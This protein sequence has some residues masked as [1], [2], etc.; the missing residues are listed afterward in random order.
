[1]SKMEPLMQQN[2]PD[3]VEFVPLAEVIDYEQP[4]KYIVSSTD[5]DDNYEIP[6]LTTGQ[7][8]ILGYKDVFE[9]IFEAMSQKSHYLK[10]SGECE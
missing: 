2:C 3:G 1:M 10:M 4:T 6:M 9:V 7:S 8:F 5:Y